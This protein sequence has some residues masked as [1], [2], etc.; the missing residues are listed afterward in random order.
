VVL[1]HGMGGSHERPQPGQPSQLSNADLLLVVLSGLS[2]IPGQAMPARGHLTGL[3][4]VLYQLRAS[5]RSEHPRSEY[6]AGR[7]R[8]SIVSIP[9][10]GL[11]RWRTCVAASTSGQGIEC[12]VQAGPTESRTSMMSWTSSSVS[13]DAFV[14]TNSAP[15]SCVPQIMIEPNTSRIVVSGKFGAQLDRHGVSSHAWRSSQ[16]SP[17]GDGVPTVMLRSTKNPV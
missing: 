15:E 2:P 4:N 17:S 7:P 8:R 16:G 12:P 13:A 11:W 5:T 9:G 10:L 1:G 14:I 3:M 6:C